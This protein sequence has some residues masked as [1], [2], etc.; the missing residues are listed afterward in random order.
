MWNSP[1][2]RT[3]EGK[4]YLAEE[5]A[6]FV[7]PIQSLLSDVFSGGVRRSVREAILARM[8]RTELLVSLHETFSALMQDTPVPAGGHPGY[9]EAILAE[10]LNR[11]TQ[12]ISAEINGGASFR[13]RQATWL[14]LSRLCPK[15]ALWEVTELGLDVADPLV[16]RESIITDNIWA[17]LLSDGGVLQA[18]F[19]WDDDWRDDRM[20]DLP[21]KHAQGVSDNLGIDLNITHALPNVSISENAQIATNYLRG[22]IA[23]HHRILDQQSG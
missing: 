21:P 23:A 12:L 11:Q 5:L 1:S 19:L 2:D 8:E 16:Y 20:L 10:L 7:H 15:E 9:Q 13:A 17:S 6:A 18:V 4:C 3:G 14:S 22:L